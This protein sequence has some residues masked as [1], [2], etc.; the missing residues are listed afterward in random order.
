M[1]RLPRVLRRRSPPS[2]RH[3]DRLRRPTRCRRRRPDAVIAHR[4]AGAWPPRTPWPRSTWPSSRAPTRSRTTSCAP[5][6][7]SSSSPTTAASRKTTDVEQVF[8]ERPRGTGRRLHPRRDQAA[9]LRIWFSAVRRSADPH[10][11]RVG[12]GRRG[13]TGMLLEAKD[14]WAFPG[15]ELDIDKELRSI[16][17]F[18]KALRHRS[19]SHAGRRPGLAAGLPRTR[20]RRAGR[21]ALLQA[22]DRRAGRGRP[23]STPSTRRSATSTRPSSSGSTSSG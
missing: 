4:G 21:A 8:P 10:P 6:T 1:N 12:R 22:P 17:T 20:P 5:R 23:G 18:V 15:I 13:S 7:G 16:P 14:P 3:R 2:P 9:R 11:A 19:R